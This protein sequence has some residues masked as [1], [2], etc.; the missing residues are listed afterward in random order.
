MHGHNRTHY[1]GSWLPA[2]GEGRKAF[3]GSRSS[4][5]FFD[6]WARRDTAAGPRAG[7]SRVTDGESEANARR[8]R[9]NETYARRVAMPHASRASWSRGGRAKRMRQCEVGQ[10]RA[11][12][13]G[14]GSCTYRHTSRC[15]PRHTSPTNTSRTKS[16]KQYKSNKLYTSPFFTT[17]SH[18]D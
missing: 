1:S 14:P 3:M 9:V 2:N 10:V 16:N 6:R 4:S 17:C 12:R 8:E 18:I 15:R 5:C 11:R 13:A 7:P